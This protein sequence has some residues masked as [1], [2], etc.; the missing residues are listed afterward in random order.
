[1]PKLTLII[2]LATSFLWIDTAAAHV[3]VGELTNENAWHAWVI[4]PDMV[5]F[6][7]LAGGI[8]LRGMQRR[9]R[10]KN[11]VSV[12]RHVFYFAGLSTLVLALQSPIDPIA[13]RLFAMHQ[14]QHTLLRMLGP[15]LIALSGPEGILIAGLPDFAR[16]NIL[17]P[18]VSNSVVQAAFRFFTR[19]VV[20]FIT[21]VASLYV[22]QI[23]SIHNAAVDDAALHYIMHITMLASGLMFFWLMFD[24]RDPPFGIPRG[25]RVLI[26]I[27]TILSNILI[28]TI[29]AMKEVVFYTVYDIDGRLFNF[30][31]LVDEATGG[32]VLWVPAGMMS[33][34]AL[35]IVIYGWNKQE[36]RL[37]QNYLNGKGR[38]NSAML[39]Y[40]QTAAELRLKVEKPNRVTA[41]SLVAMTATLFIVTLLTAINSV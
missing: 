21:F 32:F 20:A 19:P 7:L 9:S 23:P 29:T 6:T 10:I 26:L 36:V 18:V 25:G 40:P 2:A 11:P 12:W 35:L 22:W 8:Y 1:M 33:L 37:Y 3:F 13:E 39:Q 16:R 34:V 27:G 17:A 15:M 14:I 41:W 31:P 28:G 5:V 38:S 4:S 30:D 24:R